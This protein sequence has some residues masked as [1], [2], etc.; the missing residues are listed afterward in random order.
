MRCFQRDLAWGLGWE[1]GMAPQGVESQWREERKVPGTAPCGLGHFPLVQDPIQ[2]V[3]VA[4]QLSRR[5][6]VNLSALFW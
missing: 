2:S 5:L 6:N 4:Y 3:Q 1:L